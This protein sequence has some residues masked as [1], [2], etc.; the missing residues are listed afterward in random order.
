MF[1][2]CLYAYEWKVF[3]NYNQVKVFIAPCCICTCLISCEL[4]GETGSS[5]M[6]S[7]WSRRPT[8]SKYSLASGCF[9]AA[10]F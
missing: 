3:V 2:N 5:S 1:H 8:C 6:C 10:I 4:F 9:G 7:C